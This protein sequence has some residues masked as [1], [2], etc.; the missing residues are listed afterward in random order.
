MSKNTILSLEENNTQYM[1]FYVNTLFFIFFRKFIDINICCSLKSIL[2]NINLVLNELNA[3]I[4]LKLSI[5]ASIQTI[6]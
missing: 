4:I 1:K 3:V 5:K 2:N 6:K